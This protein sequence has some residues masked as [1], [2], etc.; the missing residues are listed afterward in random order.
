M[1]RDLQI[2]G[3]AAACAIAVAPVYS[4][5]ADSRQE[6]IVTARKVEEELRAVPMSVQALAGDYLEKARITRLYELQFAVPGLVI[7]TSGF[8]GA[9]FSLRGVADQ[10]VAGL[11]VAPYLNGVYLGSAN[12][13]ARM[14]DLERVEVVK[15]PQGTLYG[16]N[17]T[18]GSMN[19]ITRAPEDSF[20]GELEGS[21]GSFET[22]RARGHLN[23][24]VNNRVA[25]RFAFIAA[26]GDGYIRNS[27]DD[28]RFGEEDFWGAR[29]S[30]RIAATDALTIDLMA[31]HVRDD[32]ASSELWTPRPDFLAEPRDIRL[33]TVTQA[34]PYLVSE[35]DNADI[36]LRL[37]L[38]AIT[39]RSITAFA[40]SEVRNLDDCAGLPQLQGCVRTVLPAKFAQWSQEFQLTFLGNGHVDGLIGAYF[41]DADGDQHFRQLLPLQ[42]PRPLNDLSSHS[43]EAAAA[44]FGQASYRFAPAWTA[45]AG[46]RRSRLKKRD[47]AIGNGVQ[48]RPT[49]TIAEREEE[50]ATWRFDLQHAVSDD[51]RLYAGVST[52]YKSG[53]VIMTSLRVG[54]PD[55][56]GPE[57]VVACELGAKAQWLDRRVTLNVAAF[58]NDYKDMQVSR[59]ALRNGNVIVEVD[60]AA[61]A[62][63]Y[64][65]DTDLEVRPTDRLKF[66]AAAV[67]L[68]KREFVSYVGGANGFTLSGNTLVRSPEWSA[69]GAIDYVL[70]LRGAGELT[71]RAEYSLRSGYFYTPENEPQFF[72][73]GFG[74]LNV[75]LR[76]ESANERWYVF[77]SGKNLTGED[78]FNQVFLQSSPGYPATF[79]IGGGHRF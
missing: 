47:A 46:V 14:F 4:Q 71:T 48:D 15:G 11:S 9:G 59:T 69:T 29:G 74:L 64:G 65:I 18:G 17:S 78:Y 35:I 66:Q 60:N 67:W 39:L 21:F 52:G 62:E 68:P 36:D 50:E 2:P 16:R 44:L 20:S 37:E 79:E 23:L 61:R 75:S 6:V 72:Q 24:A 51:V 57:H 33:T 38:D 19:F 41:A 34:N 45:T 26:D 22:A 27:V 32:G 10:R 12:L 40:R 77:A 13:V 73:D 8:S 53:G 25:A 31:Q 43:E 7:N 56:F 70:P 28:R 54:D 1:R 5:E 30:L 42:N 63:I 55:E 76:F 49:L 58:R 3:I